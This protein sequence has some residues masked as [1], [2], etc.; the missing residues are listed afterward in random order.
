MFVSVFDSVWNIR[1]WHY[2]PPADIQ[3]FTLDEMFE[4]VFS[5]LFQL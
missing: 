2:L 3:P 5:K 4:Y 1:K